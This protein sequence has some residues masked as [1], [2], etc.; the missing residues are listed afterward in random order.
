MSNAYKN[1]TTYKHRTFNVFISCWM[2]LVNPN[3]R[4]SDDCHYKYYTEEP[5]F[6]IEYFYDKEYREYH[7]RYVAGHSG[8][9]SDWKTL[10]LKDS[11]HKDLW[12]DL[13]NRV[14]DDDSEGD[15]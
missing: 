15:D 2:E 10:V 12:N 5:S 8:D 3:W 1:A 14:S 11:S 7:W 13:R 6:D 4:L 9:K